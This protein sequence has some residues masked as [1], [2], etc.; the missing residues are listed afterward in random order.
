MQDYVGA[1]ELV[2]RARD[3]LPADAPALLRARVHMGLGRTEAR[4]GSAATARDHLEQAVAMASALGDDGYETLVISLIM[5]QP[6][7]LALGRHDDAEATLRRGLALATERSDRLH[8]AALLQ[9]KTYSDLGR[10]AFEEALQDAFDSRRASRELGAT[11]AELYAESVIAEMLYAHGDYER[12][13]ACADRAVA[14]AASLP[15]AAPAAP[16]LRRGRIALVMGDIEQARRVANELLAMQERLR[17]EGTEMFM[18]PENL[19]LRMLD[20]A[21]RPATGADWEALEADARQLDFQT[22]PLEV[23]E[24]R[25]RWLLVQGERAEAREKLEAARSLAVG[26]CA[27][28]RPRLTRLLE[29]ID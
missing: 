17:A 16:M 1:R 9:N 26:F 23:M 10:G 3:T 15:G 24:M 28:M 27:H 22:D 8:L 20:L 6:T 25:A 7:L 18:A 13:V 5:L 11:A 21:T 4:S 29:S 14:L 2:Y 12:A 19:L